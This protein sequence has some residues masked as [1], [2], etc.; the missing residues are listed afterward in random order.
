MI[1]DFNEFMNQQTKIMVIDIS[2]DKVHKVMNVVR[3]WQHATGI[4]I[5]VKP[6]YPDVEPRTAKGSLD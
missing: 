4:V 1:K 6:G 5:H 3:I 2:D